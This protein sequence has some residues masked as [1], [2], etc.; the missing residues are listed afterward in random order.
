M[1][2]KEAAII[3]VLNDVKSVEEPVLTPEQE[4][5]LSRALD[6]EEEFLHCIK[7]LFDKE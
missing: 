3:K 2:K 6:P 1:N 7:T 4:K 5:I